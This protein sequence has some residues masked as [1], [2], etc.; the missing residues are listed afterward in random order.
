MSRSNILIYLL[1]FYVFLQFLWWGYQIIDLGAL[2]DNS[3]EENS[4]R[5]LMIIGEGGV[6]ILILMAGFWKIQRGIAKEI[7]LSQRQ[8]NF[9]L[10]VTHELKTPL[11]SIQL[12]LQT[13]Q[14]RK[15]SESNQEV[16]VAKAI[17][18]NQR[19]SVLIDNILNASRIE[20]NGFIPKLDDFSI[21][22]FLEKK[23]EE[24]NR[25]FDHPIVSL[26]CNVE[27]IKADSFMIETIF[28]N[29]LENALKYSGT[30]PRLAISVNKH[31]K[32]IK[33]I[34]SDEGPGISSE[35][36]E[37][38]FTKFYRIGNEDTRA[39]KGSGLG[40]FITKEFVHLHRGKIFCEDN[41]PKGTKFI[42]ELP[43]EK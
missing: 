12:A 33:A 17:S 27:K 4:R 19:L 14:K 15:L 37:H 40:L 20:N 21:E 42:I 43:N 24:I 39:Q 10:S 9:M 13:L 41:I 31:E 26:S 11:T 7:R 1:A 18:E 16:L 36:R 32:S 30:E 25:S 28:N 6:F 38:I 8:I 34:V 2:V 3:N 22:N 5:V 29:L 35:E 23:K